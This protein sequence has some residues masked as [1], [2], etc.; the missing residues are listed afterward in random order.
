L[1]VRQSVVPVVFAV[2]FIMRSVEAGH[3]AAPEELLLH[4]RTVQILLA[5]WVVLILF[6]VYL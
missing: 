5:V 2:L 3:G 1:P 6:S 4:N